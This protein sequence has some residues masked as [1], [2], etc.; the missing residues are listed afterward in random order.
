[1]G[2]IERRVL[3]AAML[4]ALAML[5]FVGYTRQDPAP[6][7]Q[8]AVPVVVDSHHRVTPWSAAD[9]EPVVLQGNSGTAASAPTSGGGVRHS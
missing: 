9:V 1:M 5:G 8:R 6:V 2:K 3:T 7:P 4:G